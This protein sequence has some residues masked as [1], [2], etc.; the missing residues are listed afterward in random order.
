MF[1]ND[2]RAGKKQ[3]TRL[4]IS[5]VLAAIVTLMQAGAFIFLPTLVIL[6]AGKLMNGCVAPG[7]KTHLN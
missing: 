3:T 2:F 7:Y 4:D 1:R 5:D 6:V